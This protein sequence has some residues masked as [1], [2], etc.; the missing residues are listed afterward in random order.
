[1]LELIGRDYCRAVA[2]N[3]LVRHCTLVAESLVGKLRHGCCISFY[4]WC[5]S[6]MYFL[7]IFGAMAFGLYIIGANVILYFLLYLLQ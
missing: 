3:M 2:D 7:F 4:L 6:V 1:M 5:N